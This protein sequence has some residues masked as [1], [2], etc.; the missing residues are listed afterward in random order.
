M[1]A[2]IIAPPVSPTAGASL[3]T[4]SASPAPI[5]RP[6][7]PAKKAE[8]TSGYSGG[9]N[10]PAIAG[11]K[12]R[13]KCPLPPL[14]DHAWEGKPD[15]AFESWHVPDQTSDRAEKVYL[16]RVGKR[17]LAKWLALPLKERRSAVAEWVH[18]KRAGKGL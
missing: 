5:P 7:P 16:G 4:A 14:K 12:P 13:R 2:V 8:K 3:A 18:E 9:S 1:P 10:P 6:K 17:L 15:G 11:K